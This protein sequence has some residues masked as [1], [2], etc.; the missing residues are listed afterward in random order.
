MSDKKKTGVIQNEQHK[1]CITEYYQTI[2][3]EGSPHK[4]CDSSFKN[5]III[6]PDFL[7]ENNDEEQ[8]NT[9]LI[10]ALDS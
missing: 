6:N 7:K 2:S 4:T 9:A 1:I 5:P 3:F 10:S 8:H